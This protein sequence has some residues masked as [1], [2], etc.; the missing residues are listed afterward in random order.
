MGG[1]LLKLCLSLILTWGVVACELKGKSE[2]FGTYVANY[3]VAREKITLNEDGSFVQEVTFKATSK[4]DITK[5]KWSYDDKTG[6][7]RF[8][9]NYM[10]VLNGLGQLNT[11][12]S[13]E[14]T[15]ASLPAHTYFGY[16]VVGSEEGVLY[17]KVLSK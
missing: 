1:N 14:L 8:S 9:E 12:Y 10:N 13:Q 6:Y 15:S 5:G 16:I 2:L 7:V 3:S 11:D 4:V 17:K